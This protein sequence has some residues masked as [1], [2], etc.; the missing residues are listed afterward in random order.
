MK[1]ILRLIGLCL[2]ITGIITFIA[3][4]ACYSTIAG[5]IVFALLMTYLGV[6]ESKYEEV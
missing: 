1:D 3:L 2:A 6:R 5:T 4:I